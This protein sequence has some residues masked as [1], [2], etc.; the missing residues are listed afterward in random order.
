MAISVDRCIPCL[1]NN[2]I[3]DHE[4]G[5]IEAE[6]NIAADT[7]FEFFSN[8]LP[9]RNGAKCAFTPIGPIPGPP[10]PWGIAKVLWR[11]MCD[12]SAPNSPIRVMPTMAFRLAPSK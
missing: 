5:R 11:L 12:T 8:G 6:P 9:G 3:Y 1:P 10:P 2:L 4:I 7:A